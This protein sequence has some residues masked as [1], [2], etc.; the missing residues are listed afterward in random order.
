MP[1]PSARTAGSLVITVSILITIH[2]PIKAT[3]Y[4]K[5]WWIV[6]ELKEVFELEEFWGQSPN[7]PSRQC[8]SATLVRGRFGGLLSNI[9]SKINFQTSLKFSQTQ[10]SLKKTTFIKSIS[11]LKCHPKIFKIFK[12]LPFHSLCDVIIAFLT[13]QNMTEISKISL[14]VAKKWS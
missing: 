3:L 13:F 8:E 10:I 14:K 5:F 7:R 1:R 9:N 4:P 11:S 2:Q 12:R 6:K